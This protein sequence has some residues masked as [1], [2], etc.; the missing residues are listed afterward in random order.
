MPNPELGDSV[1]AEQQRRKSS[2]SRRRT[3]RR[4]GGD[5]GGH[6]SKDSQG[7]QVVDEPSGKTQIRQTLQR[8]KKACSLLLLGEVE[9]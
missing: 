7:V 2:A 5:V 3:G 9:H 8:M 4:R 6:V 1:E